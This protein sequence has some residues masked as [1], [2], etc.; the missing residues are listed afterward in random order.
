MSFSK[1]TICGL[2]ECGGKEKGMEMP[3]FDTTRKDELRKE[4]IRRIWGI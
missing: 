4:C 1:D 2:I 3:M